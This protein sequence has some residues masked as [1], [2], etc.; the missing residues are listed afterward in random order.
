MPNNR[1]PKHN[2][3]SA[4]G[5]SG[6]GSSDVADPGGLS[7]LRAK[8]GRYATKQYSCGRNGSIKKVGYGNEK[9][10]SVTATVVGGIL[11]LAALLDRIQHDPHAFVVRGALRPEAD[12][13]LTRRLLHPDPRDGHPATFRSACRQWIPL[14]F[15]GIAAPAIT[16]PAADP[17]DA[18]EYLIGLLPPE[19]QDATCW[20]QFT[21]S[22]GFKPDTLN[23]RL[24]FWL[25]RPMSDEDL[26]RWAKAINEAAGCPLIDPAMFRAVQP[27]YVAAP[28]FDGVKDPQPRRSGLRRGLDDAVALA[29][30]EKPAP[31]AARTG[32]S[33]GFRESAGF[34]SYLAR[35]GG[36]DG[37]NLAIY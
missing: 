19:F 11:D 30:P 18:I 4:S 6:D 12:P 7:I 5:K 37:F 26:T 27:N 31:A 16:D 8:T 36:E 1:E 10:F 22:Q 13:Q 23:A 28:I 21:S 35:I 14:D 24:W 17:E 33:T 2:A 15:D 34:E 3:S 9:W 32:V 25:D 29:L 20:W